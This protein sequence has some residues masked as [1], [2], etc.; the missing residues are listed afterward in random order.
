VTL[1]A[2]I[3]EAALEILDLEDA[4][5]QA[6]RLRELLRRHPDHRHGILE[7]CADVE[8]ADR[9]P[10]PL[11]HVFGLFRPRTT[12][13]RQPWGHTLLADDERDGSP[14]ALHVIEPPPSA[15]PELARR[16]SELVATLGTIDAR[17]VV[18]FRAIGRNDMGQHWFARDW[19]P[20]RPL[21]P[22][23]DLHA[24]APPLRSDVE[25]LADA[26]ARA[27][28]LGLAHGAIDDEHLVISGR[29][30]GRRLTLVD[31]GLQQLLHLL[32]HRASAPEA[33]DDDRRLREHGVAAVRAAPGRPTVEASRGTRWLPALALL[34]AAAA[35]GAL[36]L[37]PASASGWPDRYRYPAPVRDARTFQVEL[38]RIEAR[39][40]EADTGSAARDRARSYWFWIRA[41]RAVWTDDGAPGPNA[42][43]APHRITAVL[44]EFGQNEQLPL[45]LSLV[46]PPPADG[47]VPDRDRLRRSL[48]AASSASAGAPEA[49]APLLTALRTAIHAHDAGDPARAD[50]AL[51]A[52]WFELAAAERR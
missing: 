4:G 23:D 49:W 17:S 24:A 39:I 8:A 45:H 37:W 25:Q 41:C 12:V 29:D 18:R 52:A 19:V 1:P 5:E 16:L 31:L 10:P 47:R 46:A 40:E 32:G 44:D 21:T 3:E 2:P 48:T 13:Q 6:L 22:D 50:A 9:T 30:A 28:H 27:H 33:A 38:Q 51:A 35:I 42:S 14:V 11:G 26:I 43:F 20:G 15:D 34:L 36:S 7:I